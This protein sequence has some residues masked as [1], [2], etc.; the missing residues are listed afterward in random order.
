MAGKKRGGTTPGLRKEQQRKNTPLLFLLL[1]LIP[2]F[3]GYYNFSVLLAGV[4]LAPL[5]LYEGWRSGGFR[6]PVGPEAWCLYGVWLCGLLVI[7]FSVSTGMA[8]IGFLRQTVWV[9]FFLCAAAYTQGEREDIL[10]VIS[11]EGALL[12]LISVI[13]FVYN[14]AVGLEDRNGRI[15]GPFQYANTWALFLLVSLIVLLTKEKKRPADWGAAGALLCGMFLSGSRGVFLLALGMGLAF[16]GRYLLRNRRV[17]P[18]ICAVG[19]V[20]LIGGAA[21]ALSGG[22]VLE[23]LKAITLSSSSLNGRL[24]YYLDGLRM[25]LRHPLGLGRGGYLYQQP[26]EQTGVYILRY[27]HNEYLQ[28]ALDS[29]LPAGALTVAMAAALLFRKGLPVR[30]RAVIAAITAHACIDFDF[31]FTA[32][33]FLFLLCGAGGRSRRVSL[34]GRQICIVL[35]GV[36]VMVLGYFTAVY[37]LDFSGR[38]ARAAA[39]FPADL[40]L[41]ENRLQSCALIEDAE[42]EADRIL[43]STDLSML[44]WDCKFAACAQ[45]ADLNGMVQAKFQYLRLNKYRGEVYE[46]FTALLEQ[47][48]VQGSPSERYQYHNFAQSTIL[49]LEEVKQTTSP[50]AYRIVDQPELEFSTDISARLQAILDRKD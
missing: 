9:L 31:Q 12:A 33:V 49:L 14:N 39:M 11:Y 18:L 19:A 3:G 27:I 13:A 28:A 23:R 26:L 1:V 36:T 47:A 43:A 48:C 35:C 22:M 42:P 44:A 24:L 15:D 10:D 5:F 25:I 17:L 29:G 34:P 38:P 2:L 32:V 37:Y 20:V 6:F 45:R 7:P 16:G 40:S 21:A 30:E 50:L 46:E 4:F 8:F 41:A